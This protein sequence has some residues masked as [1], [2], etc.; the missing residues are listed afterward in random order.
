MPIVL[1]VAAMQLSMDFPVAFPKEA[2]EYGRRSS[3]ETHGVVLTKPHVVELILDLAGYSQDRDLPRMR[4]LE[5]ACGQG[6]FLVPAVERL[7]NAAKAARVKPGKLAN[8]VRAFDIDEE[9]VAISRA[10]VAEMLRLHGAGDADAGGLAQTWVR[11]G[12]F[13]LAPLDRGF[14]AVV[15]NPPYIRIEQIA[16]ALQ[17]EYRARY[18]SLYDR[19]DLYVAFIEHGLDLL[20]PRGV[21]SF[22]C[23]DRWMLNRYGAPLRRLIADQYHVQSY[24]DLHQASP[25]ESEVT[26]Y[27]AIFSIGRQSAGPVMVARMTACSPA[28]CEAIRASVRG[29]KTR[30]A[31]DLDFYPAWF[32][33]DTPWIVTSPE[34]SEILRLLES[35]FE[36]IEKGDLAHVGIGV[37][38][39]CDEVF[40][41]GKDSDIEPERLLPLVMRDDIERG[42]IR[43]AGRFVI[44]TFRDQ[45][46]VVDLHEY[47]K[48]ASYLKSHSAAVKKRH[49]AQKAP[50]N[51]FRTI[52]R[53]YPELVTKPK[54]LIPDI[55]G[56]NEVAYDEGHFHPHHNLY[57]V[58]SDRWD[59]EV[60]GGL[61]SS[62]V[63]LFLVW[64]YAVKM[65]GGYLRFQAQ[66]L[67]RIRLP[68]PDSLSPAL[69][70][71]IK[72]AFQKRDFAKL[73]ELALKAYGI[74]A[75]P[76]FEFVDTR[77]R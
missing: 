31:G 73:D 35:K 32:E 34:Q 17:A 54:L 58:T 72:K 63:A 53:V 24:V 28:E 30:A 70:V 55:A 9:H 56:S 11:Q 57:F 21:L 45:G 1:S 75:L 74:R 62:R 13:L 59:L 64:S 40:I 69:R 25:F 38:T 48:L 47:P 12:D 7:M 44:N 37:A 23:A 71:A 41:V 4:L 46:G 20:G 36:P 61:L 77:G 5:P 26:A 39:G 52:D 76:A 19:A 42:R 67:R 2:Y 43:N 65:R 33:G 14:D 27:P 50:A 22:V 16:P 60:L 29:G 15:G 68:A 3:G 18:Q 10:A 6:A 49:V 66:Y 8:C 51:W